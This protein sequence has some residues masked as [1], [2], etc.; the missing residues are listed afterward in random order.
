MSFSINTSSYSLNTNARADMTTREISN[1]LEKLSS[2][3]RINKSADDASGLL[4]ANNLRMQAS[5]LNQATANAKSAVNLVQIADNALE[6]VDKILTTIKTKSIQA[7]EDGQTDKTRLAIQKDVNRLIESLNNISKN[8]KY[9]GQNLLTGAFSNKEF[10]IGAYSNETI[11]VS[12]G[13]TDANHIGH[14]KTESLDFNSM[15]QQIDATNTVAAGAPAANFDQIVTAETNGESLTFTDKLENTT[16]TVGFGATIEFTDGD[17]DDV[18]TVEAAGDSRAALALEAT[19]NADITDNGDGSFEI[20]DGATFDSSITNLTFTV[21]GQGTDTTTSSVVTISENA[22]SALGTNDGL[23]GVRVQ[24]GDDPTTIGVSAGN[25][26]GTDPVELGETVSISIDGQGLQTIEINN[27]PGTGLGALADLINSNS[28]S[29]GT[30]ASF[31]VSAEG[32]TAVGAGNVTNLVIND[33]QIGNV[34]DIVAN[35]ADGKLVNAIN[36]VSH[37]TGVI[38]T[39]NESGALELNSADGRAIV[40]EADNTQDVM[41]L[42]AGNKFTEIGEL[43]LHSNGSND[44]LVGLK[45]DG[46]DIDSTVLE[47]ETTNS[48]NNL[49]SL[50][51]DDLLTT[52][53]GA[54]VAMNIADAALEAI[55]SIRSDIGSTQQQLNSTINNITM[56]AANVQVA[57]GG[58]RDVD[59]A[60]ET[61]NFNKYKLLAQSSAYAMSQA[62]Q[63][64][65][66]VVSLL[67]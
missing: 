20:A 4:I 24:A 1:S 60:V 55:D 27:Q 28:A 3:L 62:N 37:E 36:S 7:A 9:N 45:V 53:D 51:K 21:T 42:G 34:T 61:A 17:T 52:R 65:Q 29:V 12:I 49:F 6:E 67:R 25:I 43:T 19:T 44:I 32:S 38:A 47:R 5:S 54:Q 31:D 57:E 30:T 59:F 50:V 41:K 10:Q 23:R 16:F 64:Q 39:I 14:T 13:A 2:G 26:V 18:L 66:N 63:V 8:T 15:I 35:D 48:I 40:V 46:V 58:I 56:T 33:V 11:K 22:D